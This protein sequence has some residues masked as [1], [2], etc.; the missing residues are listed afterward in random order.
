MHIWDHRPCLLTLAHE[1]S[2][3]DQLVGAMRETIV[4]C[5]KD[6]FMPGEGYK[7]APAKVDPSQPPQ[8]GAKVGK[9]ERGRPTWYVPDVANPGQY[10]ALGLSTSPILSI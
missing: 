9:D 4:E 3:V 5:Q 7:K 10:V 6:G 1:K 8:V 2:D